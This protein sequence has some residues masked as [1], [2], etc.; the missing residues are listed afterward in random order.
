MEYLIQPS[1]LRKPLV[2]SYKGD[3][4]TTVIPEDILQLCEKQDL[5]VI[6]FLYKS[7]RKQLQGVILNVE[8]DFNPQLQVSA[9]LRVLCK[10]TQEHFNVIVVC[11][12]N[13]VVK[14]HHYFSQSEIFKV[15]VL[16]EKTIQQHTNRDNGAV[17]LLTFSNLKLVQ[18]LT[19]LNF[20]SIIVDNCDEV[21]KKK[22]LRKLQGSFNVGTEPNQ[23]LQWSILNWSNPGCV[24]KIADFYQIDNDNFAQFRDNYKEWWF[25]LTWSFCN[26][27]IKPSL[28]EKGNLSITLREWAK[29]HNLNHFLLNEEKRKRRKRKQVG[30]CKDTKSE[31]LPNGTIRVYNN[32][33]KK[34]GTAIKKAKKIEG[35]KPSDIESSSANSS[36]IIIC[37]PENIPAETIGQG[38]RSSEEQILISLISAKTFTAKMQVD[39]EIE[40]DESDIFLKNVAAPNSSQ[41]LLRLTQTSNQFINQILGNDKCKTSSEFDE[42]NIFGSQEEPNESD[43]FLKG[44]CSLNEKDQANLENNNYASTSTSDVDTLIAKVMELVKGD[45]VGAK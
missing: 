43:N 39:K 23:K 9:F 7:Y 33:T 3:K 31:K 25:R 26:S 8:P 32:T 19:D 1:A 13:S 12:D 42:L 5:L 17:L 30:L 14:W 2:L 29:N 16:T 27:F 20:F 40:D 28:E 45:N 24:G 15:C 11:P 21:V 37:K 38:N 22:A 18:S 36:G 44:I 4:A 34:K 6:D 35:L 41:N 10:A